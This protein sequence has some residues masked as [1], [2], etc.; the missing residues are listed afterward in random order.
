MDIFPPECV[1]KADQ[2]MM[3]NRHDTEALLSATALLSDLLSSCDIKCNS[4]D[5]TSVLRTL[6][7]KVCGFHSIILSQL[8]KMIIDM[9]VS[10]TDE[11]YI[12]SMLA[13][14]GLISSS[15]TVCANRSLDNSIIASSADELV[16][17]KIKSR[18]YGILKRRLTYCDWTK[19][20]RSPETFTEITNALI[21][22][23][24][25]DGC[26]FMR[27]LKLPFIVGSA[28][29]DHK[30]RR[31]DAISTG[32]S[33]LEEMQTR[34]LGSWISIVLNVSPNTDAYRRLIDSKLRLEMQPLKSEDAEASAAIGD[35]ST[36][37]STDATTE[38]ATG[39]ATIF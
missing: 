30:K 19:K 39:G 5:V 34:M 16:G 1:Y 23:A 31:I 9:Q 6:F 21:A 25:Q 28:E 27:K 26:L 38:E 20:D 12:S 18:A 11:M 8:C 35:R 7:K 22:S 33:E 32:D 24:R 4:D 3:L 10:V 2:W 37:E 14:F 13:L 17:S 36:S 29:D 15:H